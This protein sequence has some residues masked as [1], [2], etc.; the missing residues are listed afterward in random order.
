MIKNSPKEILDLLHKFLNLCLNKSLIPKSWGMEILTPILKD[1]NQNDPN[2]YRGICISSALLKVL[3][4]LLNNRI[5]EHC[6]KFNIIDKNQ[7]GFTKN[8]RTA[9]HLL[10]LRTVV[11]KYVTMGKKKLF[12]CFVDFKKAF[13]SVWHD[14]LFYKIKT[15]GICGNLLDLIKDIYKKTKCAVK[16]KGLI[17]DFFDYTKGVRQGCPLS[18]IMFNI[19][20]N[21]IFNIMNKNNKS[22]IFLDKGDKINAL[23]YADDLILLSETNEGLQAQINKL[24]DYCEKWKLEINE[25]KSKVMIFNRGNKLIKS[26][27]RINKTPVEH[28]KNFKY[29]GFSISA[30]NC[31]FSPSIEDLSIRA[32][33]AI[34]ALNNKVKLSKLPT[35]LALKLFSAQIK[36]ILLYGS[37]VWCPYMDYDYGDWDKCKIEQVHTQY[38]K[39]ILGC[40]VQTSNNMTR[41]E[42][43]NR[44]LLL[45]IIRRVISYKININERKSSTV[46]T[47]LKFEMNNDLNPNFYTYVNKF[48]V[49]TDESNRTVVHK[50]YKE[51]YDRFWGEELK[52]SPKAL[53][54]VKTKNTVCFEKYLNVVKNRKH[55]VALTRFRLSNHELQIE[56]GR[57]MRPPI[58]R[59]NRVCFCCKE[60]LEDE[61]HFLIKC[62]L[63]SENRSNLFQAC[64]ENCKNFDSLMTD[65]QK[66]IFILT[67]ESESVVQKL[68]YFVFNSFKIRGYEQQKCLPI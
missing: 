56:K 38:L 20:V 47:A 55:K 30:K 60:E 41:G 37:E 59:S 31:S 12:A 43:G 40:S 13:D 63:Y 67:N 33:R 1:G 24:N 14:G 4:T 65:Q 68:A 36:P 29:L 62:P 32:N 54:Y 46:H 45:D 35:K 42:V 50:A 39:R 64:R 28:V 57:H 8:H 3:C 11:K 16:Q 21:D 25:K 49:N 6:S 44:P 27:I 58:E 23:M 34:Y 18:P 26:E 2:N 66:F 5:Q 53:S 61:S 15:A 17:T 19:Y 7:I 52:K 22:D 10:T 9:D 51:N 48:N